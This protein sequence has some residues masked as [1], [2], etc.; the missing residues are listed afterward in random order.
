MEY[1]NRVADVFGYNPSQDPIKD[2]PIVTG[3][4]AYD[5]PRTNT[6]YILLFHESLYY[7]TELDHSLINPNQLRHFGVGVWDNPFDTTRTLSIEVN[8]ELQ[9]PLHMQGTK[10]SF[11]SR[12]PTSQELASCPHISVTSSRPWNPTTVLLQQVTFSPQV[13]SN[14]P[15]DTAKGDNHSH[16]IAILPS[17]LGLLKQLR[18]AATTHTNT[19]TAIRN[20][21]LIKHCFIALT[22]VLAT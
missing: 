2:V 7:G 17:Q 11:K 22:L 3:A 10:I 9:I 19:T 6:T 14:I 5:C 18:A 20:Q 15:I 16:F 8:D 21:T 4:T 12:S 13:V 1:T